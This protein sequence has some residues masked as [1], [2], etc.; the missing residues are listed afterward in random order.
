[1]EK[2]AFIMGVALVLLAIAGGSVEA[3]EKPL[4]A[5]FVGTLTDKTD[6]TFPGG[7][8]S[9]NR[10]KFYGSALHAMLGNL[11]LGRNFFVSSLLGRE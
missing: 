11:E 1:M 8:L 9:S 3:R 6:F 5:Q 2:R 4:H 7:P 10:A